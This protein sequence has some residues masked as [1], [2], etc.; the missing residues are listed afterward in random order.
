MKTHIESIF[1]GDSY[2]GYKVWSLIYGVQCRE[3]VIE[4]TMFG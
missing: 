2:S 1:Y 4:V 3:T